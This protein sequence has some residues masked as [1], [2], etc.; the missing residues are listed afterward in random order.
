MIK[1]KVLRAR[2]IRLDLCVPYETRCAKET[3]IARY[4]AQNLGNFPPIAVEQREDGT[5]KII[6][7]HHRYYARKDRGYRY[8]M[9]WILP[10]NYERVKVLWRGRVFIYNDTMW[11]RDTHRNSQSKSRPVSNTDV[12][13]QVLSL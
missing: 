12:L 10:H 5:F 2:R 11:T 8:I 9:A 1:T 4:K 13:V 3:Y 7:G 6:N